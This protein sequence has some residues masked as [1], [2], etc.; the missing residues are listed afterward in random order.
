LVAALLLLLV[1]LLAGG[2]GGLACGERRVM[3]GGK[4]EK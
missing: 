2:F 4:E 3:E 1:L